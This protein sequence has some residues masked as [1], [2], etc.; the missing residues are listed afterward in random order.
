MAAKLLR[1]IAM[2]LT[3]LKEA[4]NG[5]HDYVLKLESEH[6]SGITLS[7]ALIVEWANK[8]ITPTRASVSTLLTAMRRVE[9][10][11]MTEAKLGLAKSR[12]P[13]PTT[14]K[15]DELSRESRNI[16]NRLWNSV[17]G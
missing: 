15:L 1:M 14:R 10:K 6:Q 2:S 17:S 13:T 8:G 3:K 12:L 4:L 7:S 9:T 16:R 5:L 11:M